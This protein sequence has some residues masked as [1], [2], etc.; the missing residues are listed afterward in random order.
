V[1]DGCGQRRDGGLARALT[2]VAQADAEALN[3]ADR[4]G[5]KFDFGACKLEKKTLMKQI[6]AHQ[7]PTMKYL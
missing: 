2:L 7:K 4:D 3:F 5:N 6:K 1:V